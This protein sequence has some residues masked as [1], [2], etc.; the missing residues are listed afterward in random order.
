MAKRFLIIPVLVLF[1]Q[2]FVWAQRAKAGQEDDR[3]ARR[4]WEEDQRADEYATSLRRRDWLKDRLIMEIGLGTKFPV[5][6]ENWFGFGASVEYITRWHLAAFASVGFIPA[7]DDPVGFEVQNPEDPSKEA[8]YTLDGGMG[9]RVGI[10][11][12]MFPKNPIHLGFHLSYGTVYYDH[13]AE[14]NEGSL[15]RELILCRGYEFDISITYLSDQWYFLQALIGMYYIG[16]GKV[17]GKPGNKWGMSNDSWV[18]DQVENETVSLVTQKDSRPN[19]AIPPYGVV[20]GLG[21]GF[22]F[23][24][25]F[26]DDTEIRRREREKTNQ[27]VRSSSRPTPAKAAPRPT[28]K[29]GRAASINEIGDSESVEMN[30]E[31]LF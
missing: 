25:F 18:Y 19:D 12:Y 9:W 31:D 21:I 20:F 26:P 24:E 16:S 15:T 11:Y 27:N 30:D 14:P 17:D 13:K 22:A 5:M 7:H 8:N 28:N 4:Q 10:A 1:F 2:D 3:A 29:P 6:G 23:E